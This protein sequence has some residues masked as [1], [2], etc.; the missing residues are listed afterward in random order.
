MLQRS[1]YRTQ[2]SELKPRKKAANI[3]ESDILVVFRPQ[4]R[5]IS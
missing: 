3:D 4:N 5:D 2:K 1:K